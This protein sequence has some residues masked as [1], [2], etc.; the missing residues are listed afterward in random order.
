MPNPAMAKNT[1]PTTN[2]SIS[3]FLRMKCCKEYSLKTQIKHKANESNPPVAL[4]YCLTAQNPLDQLA[5]QDQ[6]TRC[7]CHNNRHDYLNLLK[8]IHDDNPDQIPA[9]T[10]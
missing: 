2:S 6:Q 5:G 4:L 8:S 7:R 9:R 3:D 10:R 1:I